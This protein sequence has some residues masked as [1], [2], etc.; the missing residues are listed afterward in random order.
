[1]ASDLGV[2]IG[3]RAFHVHQYPLYALLAFH[4]HQY[5]L[6]ALLALIRFTYV[7]RLHGTDAP[8]S[9]SVSFSPFSS[10]LLSSSPFP[11]LLPSFPFPSLPSSSSLSFSFPLFPPQLLPS[12]ST[13]IASAAAAA[14]GRPCRLSPHSVLL[15]R[16]A[17]WSP[18]TGSHPIPPLPSPP[19]PLF[20][21]FPLPRLPPS[22]PPAGSMAAGDERVWAKPRTATAAAAVPAR[23]LIVC[24]QATRACEST[25]GLCTWTWASCTRRTM[26]Y[27][28]LTT[29]KPSSDKEASFLITAFYQLHP[30]NGDRQHSSSSSGRGHG[31][32]ASGPLVPAWQRALLGPHRMLL[33]R[34]PLPPLAPLPAAR[35]LCMYGGAGGEECGS[36]RVE[37]SLLEMNL[38]P[39]FPPLSPLPTLL[40]SLLPPLP[41]SPSY[42]F[43]VSPLRL[44]PLAA[45]LLEMSAC[46]SSHALPLPQLAT[47]RL[48]HLLQHCPPCLHVLSSQKQGMAAQ[49]LSSTRERYYCHSLHHCRQQ[50]QRRLQREEKQR[51][52]WGTA[53]GDVSLLTHKLH[54]QEAFWQALQHLARLL[55]DP[56]PPPCFSSLACSSACSLTPALW[57]WELPV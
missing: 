18:L 20:P 16:S 32:L 42:P 52:H 24:S 14:G 54:W 10:V 15:V 45:W 37:T 31:P 41:P 2:T 23:P 8:D 26:I 43:P 50:G 3:Q 47:Q 9:P 7:T 22:P 27:T 53:Y 4:V 25:W 29:Q 30:V 36:L 35:A 5:P 33:L 11:S 21:L 51:R 1:M 39:P 56:T 34:P 28:H 44:L 55:P 17:D 13:V 46:G 6:Y 38:K 19:F 12:L 40:S 48:Q 57:G 49:Q